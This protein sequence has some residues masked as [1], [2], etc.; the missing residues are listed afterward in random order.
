MKSQYKPKPAIKAA[1]DAPRKQTFDKDGFIGSDSEDEAISKGNKM[2]ES[3]KTKR[4]TDDEGGDQKE[5]PRVKKAK[6][7]VRKNKA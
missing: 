6:A 2:G 4:G 7:P 1:G 5:E 3:G